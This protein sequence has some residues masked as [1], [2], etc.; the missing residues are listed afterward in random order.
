MLQV[1]FVTFSYCGHEFDMKT[2]VSTFKDF[3]YLLRIARD[4]A[5]TLINLW[6]S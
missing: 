1:E 2:D 3:I 6:S 4:S 5:H